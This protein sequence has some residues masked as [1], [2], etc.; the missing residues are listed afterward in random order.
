[1]AG[2]EGFVR[3]VGRGS[4]FEGSVRGVGRGSGAFGEGSG[5]PVGR[6]S[7]SPA[8]DLAS[9]SRRR[10]VPKPKNAPGNRSKGFL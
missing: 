6:G 1:M 7:S 10:V 4:G 2:R 3:G 5:S 8:V 9:G